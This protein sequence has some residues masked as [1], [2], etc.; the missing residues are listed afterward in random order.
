MSGFRNSSVSQQTVT[1]T[2][3]VSLPQNTVTPVISS[4]TLGTGVYVVMV[5]MPF[6]TGAGGESVDVTAVMSSGAA[7]FSGQY[8]S[9]AGYQSAGVA[10]AFYGVS[11]TFIAVVT[12]PG[13]LTINAEMA[14]NTTAATILAK[15]FT[16]A[17]NNATGMTILKIG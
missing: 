8:S 10:G 16:Q 12:A 6:D 5:G 3:N 17:F 15:S 7:T 9:T 11:L 4:N 1:I 14:G 2:S 13:V